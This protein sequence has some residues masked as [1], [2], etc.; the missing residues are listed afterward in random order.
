MEPVALIP[1]ATL[2]VFAGLFG[3][4]ALVLTIRARMKD[5]L[6]I[7]TLTGFLLTGLA[8]VGLS[9]FLLYWDLGPF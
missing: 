3:L 8:A 4:A 6:P 5:R 2:V 1:P 7:G 9:S